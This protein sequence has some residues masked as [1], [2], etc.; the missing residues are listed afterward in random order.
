MPNSSSRHRK[1]MSC[2]FYGNILNSIGGQNITTERDEENE[3]K[4]EK[5][6][7]QRRRMN[8]LKKYIKANRNKYSS[9]E[10]FYEKNKSYLAN[11]KLK[12]FEHLIM[13][14][15]EIEKEEREEKLEKELLEKERKKKILKEIRE[16]KVK[17]NKKVNVCN[18]S[19]N[20]NKGKTI[21]IIE[22]NNKFIYFPKEPKKYKESVLKK[23]NNIS[24]ISIKQSNIY[25]N[26]LQICFKT[27]EYNIIP[28]INEYIK[29]KAEKYK[30][31]SYKKEQFFGNK[32]L[33]YNESELKCLNDINIIYE[34]TKIK[35]D[36]LNQNNIILDELRIRK[37]RK[38]KRISN[39][40]KVKSIIEKIENENIMK[41][42]IK[43]RNI[44][45]SYI[46][47]I[48]CY[49]CFNSN[50]ADSHFGHFLFKIDDFRNE[51]YELDYN[52]R[53]NILYE[54]LKKKK[55]KLMKNGNKKLIKYYGK[56]L[57]SIYDII[58]NNN[59]Y[60][61]LILSI[62]NINETF[63]NEL[64]SGTFQG[65]FKNIFLLFYQKI[66]LLTYLK[67]KEFIFNELDEEKINKN[68]LENELENFLE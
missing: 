6:Y 38:T 63:V 5:I 55:K 26:L 65:V 36:I 22:N 47:C 50:E 54:I 57:L 34:K 13:L 32:K 3:E 58:S 35:K 62:I 9:N 10:E 52:E 64:K 59:S 33:K 11:S 51:D 37:K 48:N 27:N 67:S 41:K 45:L 28:N 42:I 12:D 60:E 56:L 43:N 19:I 49:E 16:K 46:F 39:E 44:P 17:K 18:F 2:D 29:N 8:P 24:D 23:E 21:F 53:L 61:E 68:G 15:N 40:E 14:V 7:E 1:R 66:S 20:L 31:E 30:I 4:I 25:S